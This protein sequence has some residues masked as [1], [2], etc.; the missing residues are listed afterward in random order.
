VR[1]TTNTF[2]SEFIWTL[3][4]WRWRRKKERQ[5]QGRRGG[6]HKNK[7]KVRGKGGEE[8]HLI[9]HDRSADAVI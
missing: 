6:L 8:G 2:R 3:L 7:K 5:G 1:T 4:A 9:E